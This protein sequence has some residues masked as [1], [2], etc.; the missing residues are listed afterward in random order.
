[1]TA[2]GPDAPGVPSS[3]NPVQV[4]GNDGTNVRAI[5]TDANGNSQVAGTAAAGAAPTGNPISMG[6][7]D[8]TNMQRLRLDTSGR[9]VLSSDS[10][11]QTDDQPNTPSAIFAAGAA[12]S[13][14]RAY[15]FFY[16]EPSN[17]WDRIRGNNQAGMQIA[18]R[19]SGSSG[20]IYPVLACDSSAVIN[21]TAGATLEIVSTTGSRSVRVCAFSLSS[22][23]A[24][25]TARWVHGTGTNCATSTTNV[26][27]AYSMGANTV[28]AYGSGVGE[29]F[30][31]V[32]GRNLCL[33]AATGNITGLLSYV[34]F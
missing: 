9:I 10:T 18:G 7:T 11:S 30:K 28:I 8:G 1:M 31:T 29:L 2:I 6:G 23:T 25:S 13:I 24:S 20:T 3:A 34:V 21:V 5:R 17:N 12:G 22:D 14:I 26:T 15:P 33:V 27:G 32:T 16:D 19:G 4:A